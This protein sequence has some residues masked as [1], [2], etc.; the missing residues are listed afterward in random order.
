VGL[1]GDD[2]ALGLRQCCGDRVSGL[3]EESGHQTFEV[4][5]GSPAGRDEDRLRDAGQAINRWSSVPET[6]RVVRQSGSERLQAD[7]EMDAQIAE[8]GLFDP[9]QSPR[10]VPRS[11][12]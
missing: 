12:R 8:S 10:R 9:V 1:A 11:R 3:L 7:P 6:R 2:A 5:V 4:R